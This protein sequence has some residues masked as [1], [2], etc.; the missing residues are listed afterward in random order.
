L[1]EEERELEEILAKKKEEILRRFKENALRDNVMRKRREID[2]KQF[3]SNKAWNYLQKK[4]GSH[5][6]ELREILNAV[7]FLVRERLISKPLSL[8]AI[9]FISRRVLG[10]E[11]RIIILDD[12][13]EVEI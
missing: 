1:D 11:S 6:R 7:E 13:K 5:P 9:L 2:V 8:E 4:Y 10:E 3:I 12:D